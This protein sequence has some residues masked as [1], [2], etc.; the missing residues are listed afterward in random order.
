MQRSL[1]LLVCAIICFEAGAFGVCVAQTRSVSPQEYVAWA[2]SSLANSRQNQSAGGEQGVQ[3]LI[4]I[5]SLPSTDAAGAGINTGFAPRVAGDRFSGSVISSQVTNQTSFSGDGIGNTVYRPGATGDF[6][7]SSFV[8]PSQPNPYPS[9]SSPRIAGLGRP[10][11]SRGNSN[12]GSA[13]L[14]GT[15]SQNTTNFG[16][17]NPAAT[18]SSG[19]QGANFTVPQ[20][21]STS[22]L[23]PPPYPA[24]QSTAGSFSNSA[25]V[26]GS[27][28]NSLPP[29][30]A[31]RWSSFRQT[32]YQTPT[33]GLGPVGSTRPTV[34]PTSQSCYCAPTAP[35]NAANTAPTLGGGAVAGYYAQAPNLAAPQPLPYQLPADSGFPQLGGTAPAANA[36]V[37]R[38]NYPPGTYLGQGIIGQPTAYVDGQPVR[39]LMRYIFP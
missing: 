15:P 21:A 8:P 19:F 11:F 37:I 35:A 5:A 9:M 3:N 6:D 1:A 22:T 13:S 39:N 29:E 24:S 28:V 27:G 10:W 34:Y 33:L 7:A 17:A 32:A 31:G 4:E 23:S 18:T 30:I 26:T 14:S 2:S 20:L 36:V 25:A 12:L 38:Q 16:A